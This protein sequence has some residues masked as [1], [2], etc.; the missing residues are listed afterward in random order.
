VDPFDRDAT[1][2]PPRTQAEEDAFDQWVLR[3]MVELES[4]QEEAS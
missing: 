3:V 2:P 1:L 4:E